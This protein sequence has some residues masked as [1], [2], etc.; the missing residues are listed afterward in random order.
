[1]INERLK[2]TLL[3]VWLISLS[4]AMNQ[5]W[6]V[7]SL[8]ASSI[9]GGARVARR[10]ALMGLIFGLLPGVLAWGVMLVGIGKE[11]DIILLWLRVWSMTSVALVIAYKIHWAMLLRP[12]PAAAMVVAL[13]GAQAVWLSRELESFSE[14]SR[15]RLMRPPTLSERLLMIQT[16]LR[17]FAIRVVVRA[18]E[19]VMAMKARGYGSL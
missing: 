17:F 9:Y 12:W 19:G 3:I 7:A 8:V 5:W 4:L 13:I 6:M 10:A 2:L 18:Q 1:M 16:Q 14:A 11:A 15:A